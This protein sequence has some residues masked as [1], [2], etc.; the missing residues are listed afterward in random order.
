MGFFDW[1]SQLFGKTPTEETVTACNY[2][3]KQHKS[4]KETVANQET[5]IKNYIEIDNENKEKITKLENHIKVKENDMTNLTTQ[6]DERGIALDAEKS[7]V[8]TLKNRIERIKTECNKDNN[9]K[10]L[11]GVQKILAEKF[12]PISYSCSVIVYC[13]IALL[14]GILIGYWLFGRSSQSYDESTPVPQQFVNGL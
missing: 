1:F 12:S 3:E 11:E 4:C 9:C 14:F 2:D 7:K 8:N 6:Y 5:V 13:I 10:K